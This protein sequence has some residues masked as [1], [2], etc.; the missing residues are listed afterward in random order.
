MKI[1]ESQTMD[2][3]RLYPIYY[4]AELNFKGILI[5]KFPIY[6]LCSTFVCCAFSN[7]TFTS[8]EVSSLTRTLL[9]TISDGKT[10]SSRIES[11]TAVR[12]RLKIGKNNF[13][14]K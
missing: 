10:K 7:T 8:R 3:R 5:F 11:W 2:H 12:V 1:C 14:L 6:T 9:P 13:K 4:I